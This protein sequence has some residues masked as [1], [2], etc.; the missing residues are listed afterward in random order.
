MEFLVERRWTN[1]SLHRSYIYLVMCA[2]NT[3]YDSYSCNNFWQDRTLIGIL[4]GLTDLEVI[5]TP[6][7]TKETILEST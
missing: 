5:N 2:T 4:P 3:G 1:K 6:R 7:S